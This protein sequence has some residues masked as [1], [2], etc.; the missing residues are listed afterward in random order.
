MILNLPERRL[1][2]T[3]AGRNPH[4]DEDRS[5]SAGDCA[6]DKMISTIESVSVLPWPTGCQFR[7]G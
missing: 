1:D 3:R 5:N 2:A 7:A 6:R 4:G